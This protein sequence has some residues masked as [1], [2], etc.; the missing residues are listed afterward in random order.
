MQSEIADLAEQ[1]GPLHPVQLSDERN[2]LRDKIVGHKFA[3]LLLTGSNAALEKVGDADTER[4]GKP[5]QRRE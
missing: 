4:P 5:L 3:N 1:A 2:D